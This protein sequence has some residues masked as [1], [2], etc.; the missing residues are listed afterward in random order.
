MKKFI[1]FNKII[2][3]VFFSFI[4]VNL[5]FYVYAFIT[6]KFNINTNSNIVYYDINGKDIFEEKNK[7]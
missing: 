3:F 4:I 6:P 2:I 7:I 5:S 1:I